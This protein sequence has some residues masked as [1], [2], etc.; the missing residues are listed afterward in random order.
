MYIPCVSRI[1][2]TNLQT[3][4]GLGIVNDGV[5]P[6]HSTSRSSNQ[7]FS[8]V[9]VLTGTDLEKVLY[10]YSLPSNFKQQWTKVCHYKL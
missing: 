7:R 6:F 2:P 3:Y 10:L 1:I 8:R 4:I 5:P 9:S